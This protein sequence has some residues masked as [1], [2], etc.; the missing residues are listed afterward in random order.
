MCT[1]HLLLCRKRRKRN[2]YST[3]SRVMCTQM[4]TQNTKCTHLKPNVYNDNQNNTPDTEENRRSRNDT[5]YHVKQGCG[6]LRKLGGWTTM[7]GRSPDGGR[8]SWHDNPTHCTCVFAA[9]FTKFYSYE[10]QSPMTYKKS[11]RKYK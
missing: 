4:N 6:L 2:I 5:C 8:G 10:L 3:E 1:L 11:N 7:G 9:I